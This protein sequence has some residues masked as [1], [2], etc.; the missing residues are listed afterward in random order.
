MYFY[1]NVFQRKIYAEYSERMYIAVRILPRQWFAIYISSVYR[2]ISFLS[3]MPFVK[4]Q[5]QPST[6]ALIPSQSL[7][8]STSYNELNQNRTER[9]CYRSDDFWSTRAQSCKNP[10][11]RRD[12]SKAYIKYRYTE[13]VC[14]NPEVSFFD[15]SGYRNPY[16]HSRACFVKD[17]LFDVT[18][19]G[20]Y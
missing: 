16:Q 8:F 1:S 11:N 20:P 12:F 7:V 9:T 4:S 6:I 2:Q 17:Q 13:K 19:P 5:W 3:V 15:K 14:M 10:S 18:R